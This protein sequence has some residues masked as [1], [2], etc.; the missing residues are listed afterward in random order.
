MGWIQFCDGRSQEF[1]WKEKL[2]KLPVA[3]LMIGGRD[4]LSRYLYQKLYENQKECKGKN[5]VVR[6]KGATLYYPKKIFEKTR[7]VELEGVSLSVPDAVDPYLKI[8]FGKGYMNKLT[9]PYIPSMTVITSTNIPCR[10]FLAKYSGQV[11][12]LV[13]ERRG[14]VQQRQKRAKIP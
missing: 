13:K 4:R 6:L 9:E 10:E 11:K 7:R 1:T 5:Y 8:W 12:T 3:I 14:S 2:C